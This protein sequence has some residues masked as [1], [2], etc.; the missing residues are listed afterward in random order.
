MASDSWSAS[1]VDVLGA[2]ESAGL[3]RYP[4]NISPEYQL[5]ERA[6]F[7]IATSGV[8]LSCSQKSSRQFRFLYCRGE[9][10]CSGPDGQEHELA[11]FFFVASFGSRH[12]G[13]GNG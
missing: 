3:F 8:V 9:G 6:W 11:S 10:G 1:G 5:G 2:L 13:A 12:A 4:P 7:D